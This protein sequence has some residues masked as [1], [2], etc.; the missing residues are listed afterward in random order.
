MEILTVFKNENQRQSTTSFNSFVHYFWRSKAKN[1]KFI[2]SIESSSYEVFQPVTWNYICATLRKC[3]W[4]LISLALSAH[5]LPDALNTC[6][7]TMYQIPRIYS[8]ST[9]STFRFSNSF[10]TFF[11]RCLNTS[12]K[13]NKKVLSSTNEST[14]ESLQF[15]KRDDKITNVQQKYNF[16]LS[17][18]IERSLFSNGQ[19]LDQWE[20]RN[21]FE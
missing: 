2:L 17:S 8:L 1:G 5:S 16:S 21:N 9:W 13:R 12:L 4:M 14:Q 7:N 20:S 10:A 19:T 18:L 11:C 3:P 6:A 15:K